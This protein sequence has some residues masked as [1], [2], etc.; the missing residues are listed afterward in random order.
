MFA[1]H[2]IRTI[3]FYLFLAIWTVLWTTPM[4]VLIYAVPF[5]LRHKIFVTVWAKVALILCRILCGIKWSVEGS[6]NIPESP[7]VIISNHQSTWETFYFQTLLSPQTQVIKQEILNVPFF[8]W[9]FKGIKPIAIDRSDPRRSLQQVRE[10]G[11]GSLKNKIWV[12][13]FPEGT[14]NN[15]GSLGKFSK[16]AAGLAKSADVGVLPVAHNAGVYWPGDHWVKRPGTIQVRIGPVIDTNEISVAEVNQKS[17]SWIEE[18]LENLP[19]I[20]R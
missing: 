8:G 12:L 11:V 18:S 20:S 16:G 13:I 17:R 19:D 1:V 7:C 15:P 14:R 2:L 4:M 3:L 5:R 9:A 6:D 10:Q